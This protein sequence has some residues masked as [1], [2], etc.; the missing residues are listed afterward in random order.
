MMRRYVE[1]IVRFRIAVIILIAI[2][3]VLIG[4]RIKEL[5]VEVDPDK[6]L[7]QSHPYVVAQNQIDKIFGRRNIVVIGVIPKEGDIFQPKILEKIMRITQKINEIPGAIKTNIFSIAAK[8][9]K[10]IRGTEEGLD[11]LRNKIYRNPLFIN[12]IIS[13]DCS[14]AQIIADFRFNKEL[15]GYP[16][17][18]K[19][20]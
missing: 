19:R 8:K 9:A 11:E 20:I 14:A 2:V 15:K 5:K 4:S 17:I 3:T 16:D 12:S 18:E 13:K 1:N 10:D 6:N 7:P